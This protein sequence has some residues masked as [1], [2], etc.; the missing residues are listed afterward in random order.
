MG[1]QSAGADPPACYG[2]G[3]A[4]PT[5]T[6]ANLV[7]GYLS[8]E[9]FAGGRIRLDAQAARRAIS[10]KIA[11][12][13][14]LTLVEAARGM[15]HLINVNM[16]A[17]IREISVRKGYDPRDF[18]LICAGGAGPIHGAS[19]AAELDM[20]AVILPRESSIF[21]ASGMLRT[22]LK[23]DYV[24]SHARLLGRDRADDR[25]IVRLA[26]EMQVLA[27]AALKAEGIPAAR[28]RMRY[29]M[30]L[31]YLGQYHEVSVDVP[32]SAIAGSNWDAVRALFPTRHDRLYGYSLREDE[33]PV[34]LLNIRLTAIG[35]T[36]KPP[37]RAEPRSRADCRAALKDRR[38][39]YL[40]SGRGFRSLPVYDGDRLRHGNRLAGPAI[41]ES[42]NTSILVPAGY[43]AAYDA[44]GNCVLSARRRTGRAQP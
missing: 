3:G 20:D 8:A 16:A 5:C 30:D 2:R 14:G 19:I 4:E 18:P 36:T 31:R 33:T 29:R 38:P 37:L 25:R 44:A 1:P 6:D 32:E 35:I 42:V 23:H 34:E 40:P 28:Q 15:F 22:D 21:C 7:L 24:R 39:V 9:Y 17:A 10:D 26:R 12:P 11:K 41:I 27:R 43:A 13:L